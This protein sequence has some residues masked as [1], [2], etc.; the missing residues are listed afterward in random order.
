MCTS[1]FSIKICSL[2]VMYLLGNGIV[3]NCVI[4]FVVWLFEEVRM[5]NIIDDAVDVIVFTEKLNVQR[6][7]KDIQCKVFSVIFRE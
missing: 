6:C 7:T 4:R 1:K 5:Q 3:I 2:S